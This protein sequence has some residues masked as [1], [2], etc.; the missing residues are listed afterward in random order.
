LSP[1]V[2]SQLAENGVVVIAAGWPFLPIQNSHFVAS[3]YRR[4]IPRLDRHFEHL[5]RGF[6]PWR[7]ELTK[8]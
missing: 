7:V 6:E 2:H 4:H 1:L 5:F 8:Q 3:D